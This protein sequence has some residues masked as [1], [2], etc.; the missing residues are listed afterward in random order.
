[1]VKTLYHIMK[2]Q[3][4]RLCSSDL[5]SFANDIITQMMQIM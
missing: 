2:S 5:T 1:M 3:F 4:T